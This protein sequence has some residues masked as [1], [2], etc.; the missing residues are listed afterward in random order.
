MPTQMTRWIVY[1][2]ILVTLCVPLSVSWAQSFPWA[3]EDAQTVAAPTG[4][5]ASHLACVEQETTAYDCHQGKACVF[6]ALAASHAVPRV[7]LYLSLVTPLPS[8][9]PTAVP[10]VEQSVELQPPKHLHA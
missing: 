2:M 8:L 6:C 7:S 9:V 4:S 1:T 10:W 5:P 3:A